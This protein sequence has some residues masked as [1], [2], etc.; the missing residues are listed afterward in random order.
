MIIQPAWSGKMRL[1]GNFE[2]GK[3]QG[4]LKAS[5]SGNPELYD[6]FQC[7]LLQVVGHEDNGGGVCVLLLLLSCHK[8]VVVAG[9]GA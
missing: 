5:M 6:I 7:L 2:S 9:C 4:I 8:C 3:S 1:R